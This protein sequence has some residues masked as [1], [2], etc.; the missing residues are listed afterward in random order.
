M[1]FL[2]Y[3]WEDAVSCFLCVKKKLETFGLDWMSRAIFRAIVFS[4]WFLGVSVG[5]RG[6]NVVGKGEMGDTGSL[7]R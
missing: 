1:I 5:G 4:F 6:G 7:F 3:F 2:L